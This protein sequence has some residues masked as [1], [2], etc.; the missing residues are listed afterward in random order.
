MVEARPAAPLVVVE[1]DLLLEFLVIA[2]DAPTHFGGVDEFAEG[3]LLGEVRKPILGGRVLAFRPLDQPRLFR[4]SGGAPARRG[5]HPNA[6]K[7]RTQ[8]LGRA[9][10]PSGRAPRMVWPTE[11]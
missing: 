3:H 10:P 1:P 2:L 7:A 5:A 8:R 6:G 4:A 9:V 11:R